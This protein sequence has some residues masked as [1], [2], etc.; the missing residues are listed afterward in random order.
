MDDSLYKC[1][2]QSIDRRKFNFLDQ[3]DRHRFPRLSSATT[4]THRRI[5]SFDIDCLRLSLIAVDWFGLSLIAIV[6]LRFPST[7]TDRHRLS[8]I[9]ISSRRQSSSI[10]VFGPL[11]RERCLSTIEDKDRFQA[12]QFNIVFKFDWNRGKLLMFKSR[13]VL[14]SFVHWL[15]R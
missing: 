13:N 15:S 7:A 12:L 14:S 10:D 4:E 9:A 11:T 3:V 1:K 8:S 6:C 5:S 2:G